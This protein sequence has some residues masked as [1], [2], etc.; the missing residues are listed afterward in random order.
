MHA[1][2]F[3]QRIT[4]PFQFDTTEIP[5]TTNIL[6]ENM[7][8][9]ENNFVEGLHLDNLINSF[10]TES[11]HNNIDSN[12]IPQNLSFSSLKSKGSHNCGSKNIAYIDPSNDIENTI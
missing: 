8:D 7:P 6:E 9:E 12:N 11:T 5:N 1:Q 4:K 3:L 10:S 2:D